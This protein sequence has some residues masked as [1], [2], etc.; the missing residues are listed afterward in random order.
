MR[1]RLK[2][3]RQVG[4]GGTSSREKIGDQERKE[5]KTKRREK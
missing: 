4:G 5:T 3:D 2:I 1:R